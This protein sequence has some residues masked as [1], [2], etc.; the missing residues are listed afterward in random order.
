M[1]LLV[2]PPSQAARIETIEETIASEGFKVAAFTGGA[3]DRPQPA[4]G[5]QKISA[6]YF[7]PLSQQHAAKGKQACAV[8]G[9][10]GF[11]FEDAFEPCADCGAYAEP[12][13]F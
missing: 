12:G 13:D 1:W 11:S 8:K 2:S 5:L 7:F 10:A 3:G 4:T 6:K 9:G